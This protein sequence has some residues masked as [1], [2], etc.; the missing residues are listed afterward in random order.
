MILVNYLSK[1]YLLIILIGIV[2]CMSVDDKFKGQIDKV[3]SEIRSNDAY[4]IDKVPDLKLLEELRLP[5][6]VLHFYKNYAPEEEIVGEV[7]I[8]SI[9]GIDYNITESWPGEQI[10]KFGYLQFATSHGGDA[11]CLDLNSTSRKGPRVVFISHEEN[12]QD[13]THEL[14]KKEMFLVASDFITFLEMFKNN[15][16][17]DKFD[18]DN[19]GID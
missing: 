10:V 8:Q 2:G 11:Y 5:Q 4:S 19:P 7:I 16:V 6:V 1:S 9:S 12:Y 14:L 15:K 3:V 13:Y 17:P 18:W